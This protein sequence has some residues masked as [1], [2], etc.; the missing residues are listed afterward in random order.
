MSNKAG[1]VGTVSWKLFNDLYES[2]YDL[3]RKLKFITKAGKLNG[4]ETIALEL[5]DGYLGQK[6]NQLKELRQAALD[7]WTGRETALV[8]QPGNDR[9]TPK[10]EGGTG[11]GA[12]KSSE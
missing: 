8:L 7:E 6:E 4:A 9:I 5:I 10:N 1:D 2:Q 11:N 3:L 12:I